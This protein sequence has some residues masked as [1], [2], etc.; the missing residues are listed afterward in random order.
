MCFVHAA[1]REDVVWK[2]PIYAEL[3]QW[4]IEHSYGMLQDTT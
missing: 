3:M 4:G 2:F 1:F